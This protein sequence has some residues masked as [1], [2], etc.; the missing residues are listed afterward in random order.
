MSQLLLGY[1]RPIRPR[2]AGGDTIGEQ[3]IFLDQEASRRGMTLELIMEEASVGSTLPFDSRLSHYRNRPALHN[4]L[5]RLDGGLALGLAVA[6]L[7]HLCISVDDFLDVLQRSSMRSW[8]LV[9][10][11]IWLDTF[12]PMGMAL[13]NITLSFVDDERSR[14]GERV[15]EI[16]QA[17]DFTN[18]MTSEQFLHLV[19]QLT[20]ILD[21]MGKSA[22]SS[23]DLSTRWN[24]GE[25]KDEL[26]RRYKRSLQKSGPEFA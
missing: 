17:L 18:D 8:Q 11:D 4:A 9:V 25:I 6:S 13:S 19:K 14:L 21:I 10:G 24:L 3:R 16:N 5:E 2:I 23:R 15:D 1:I 7:K 26:Q 20:G 12:A 22:Q